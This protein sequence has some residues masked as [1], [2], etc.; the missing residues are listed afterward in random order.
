MSK[1]LSAKDF[2]KEC[3]AG[4][5]CGAYLFFGE[6]EY[7]KNH[8]LHAARRAL[9]GE[10]EDDPFNRTV[11]SGEDDGWLEALAEQVSSM[12]MFAEK[13][14]IELH[15]VPYNKLTEKEFEE[16]FDLLRVQNE[17]EDSVLILYAESGE[18]DAGPVKKKP[19][20]LYKRFDKLNKN[21][22]EDIVKTV[23]FDYETPAALNSWVVRHFAASGVSCTPETAAKIIEYCSKDMYALSGET[24]KLICYTL[25][26]GRTAVRAEDIEKVCC[27]KQIDGAFDFTDALMNGGSARACR[28]LSNMKEKRVKPEIILGGVVDTLG[29]MFTVKTL[30]DGGLTAEQIEAKTGLHHYRVQALLC[31]VRQKKTARLQRALGLCME[32]DLQIK[33]SALDDYTVLDKLVMRLC[34]V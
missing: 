23:F 27:G 32:A 30:S 28:L 29:N 24:D 22:S 4:T 1:L 12:P 13:K 33:S 7:L 18:F 31:A 11:I 15:A 16:L 3:K 20:E 2:T 9:F 19:S 25:A 14:L 8:C 6:E 17:S 26:D 21:K 10:E 5:L 34:R